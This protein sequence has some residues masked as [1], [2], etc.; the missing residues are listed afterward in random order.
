MTEIAPDLDVAEEPEARPRGDLLEH[1]RDRLDVRVV[2]R[3]AQP[4]KAPR[5]GQPVE[6]VDLDRELRGEELARGIE[7]GRA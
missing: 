1:A 6:E 4:D 7:P 3:D 5:C 2:G